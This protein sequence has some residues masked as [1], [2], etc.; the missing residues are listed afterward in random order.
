MV[1]QGSIEVTIDDIS[2]IDEIEGKLSSEAIEERLMRSVA[3]NDKKNVD[4]GQL[5]AEALNQGISSFNPDMMFENMVNNYSMAKKV[6]GERLIKLLSGYNSGFIER[7]I[8]IPEFQ[9]ELKKK[10]A[11]KVQEMKDDSLLTRSDAVSEIGATLSALVLFA[12][13]LER[14]TP[15]GSFG[16]KPHKR[17]S[18]YGER[19][20]SRKYRKGDRYKD[21]AI[22]DS[23]KLAIRRGHRRVGTDDLV[24]SDRQSRGQA[25]II[26]AIDASG[27]MK[28]KKIAVCKK[29]GI[30]L[31]YKGINARDKIGLI[32]FGSDIKTEVTPSLD[33]PFLLREIAKL[34]ATRQTDFTSML[35]RC[36]ELF[37]TGSHTKHLIILTDATPT[38]GADPQA[39]SLAAISR[40]REAGIT[41]SIIGIEMDQK[42][43]TFAEH[44]AEIGKGKVYLVKAT[45]ELDTIVLEDY[46]SIYG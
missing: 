42:A 45:D 9:R 15:K 16:E 43:R 8:N 11:E 2:E 14:I 36:L 31:A 41:V 33:F 5:I 4:S 12:S 34:R 26:Y 37:S 44:A 22:K 27:S 18:H 19:D 38:V 32:A 21:I 29:A 20:T 3:Q 23:L 35:L 40:I 13:E 24:V 30:A 28:G 1:M 46:Y 25:E 17:R 7:N 6:Y 10:I 39:E